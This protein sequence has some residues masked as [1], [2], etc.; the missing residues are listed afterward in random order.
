M[1]RRALIERRPWL[2]G[3]VLAALAFIWLE[4]SRLPGL[5]L[6]G[7]KAAPLLFLAVYA[8]LRHRGNDT[9]M[10][11]GM[12]VCEGVGTALYDYLPY[13]SIVLIIIGFGLGIGLFT[14]H[15]RAQL[16]GSQK[17]AVTA[18]LLITPVIGFL[19]ASPEMRITALVFMVA[20]GGMAA[21]AW[22][23]TFPRYRVGAGAVVIMAANLL[24]IAAEGLMQRELWMAH[25]AWPLFYFGNLML[26]TGVTV[27]LRSRR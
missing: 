13:A 2:L 9:R 27:E 5:Y 12:L 22:A 18:I 14:S 20:V 16:T 25:F 15:R 8:V 1:P 7:L 26:S 23:S 17:A 4:N 11:A 10:L 6:L 21:S 3:S 24:A 19:L